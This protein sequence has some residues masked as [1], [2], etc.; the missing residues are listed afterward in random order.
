[1]APARL[2]DQ[3][4]EIGKRPELWMDV[5]VVRDVVAPI[6]VRRREGRAE[7]HGVDAE[8]LQVVE[9]RDQPLQSPI[10]S[11]FESA[12]EREYT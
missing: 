9:L 7:P 11:A 4:L 3:F 10:P 2:D 1:V 12:Y 5:V 6:G 8:P